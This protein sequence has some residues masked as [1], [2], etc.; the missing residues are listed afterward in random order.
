MMSTYGITITIS[1]ASS[2]NKELKSKNFTETAYDR[3]FKCKATNTSNSTGT[4]AANKTTK[5]DENAEFKFNSTHCC[6]ASVK[7]LTVKA[8]KEAQ[9]QERDSAELIA[10]SVPLYVVDVLSFVIMLILIPCTD[11]FFVLI[12][13]YGTC[14]CVSKKAAHR[15]LKT[16]RNTF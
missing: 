5:R 15:A 13:H 10:T 16:V 4:R 2:W 8:Y 12:L 1:E 9:T 6:N 7:V 14:K 11:K 3:E